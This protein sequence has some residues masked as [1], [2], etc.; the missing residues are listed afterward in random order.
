MI[1]LKTENNKT[2]HKLRT[3]L[4]QSLKAPIDAMW[5]L[6][7]IASSKH[8][9]IEEDGE[10]IG[11][12][13]INEEGALLQIYLNEDKALNM[14]GVIQKLLASNLM[15][16]ANLSSN[17]PIGFNSC[18]ALSKSIEVNTFCFENNNK[19][20]ITDS[21]LQVDLVSKVDIPAIKSF[22]MEQIGMDDNFG[23]TENLVGRKE[24]YM[25]KEQDEIIAISECRISDSQPGIVDLG[26]IV[27]KAFQGKGI[28]SQVF[29]L[30]VNRVLKEGNKPICSTTSDNIASRKAIEKAGFYCSN[31]IFNIQF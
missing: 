5:E 29:Q 12:C 16:S 26:I 19:S 9:L 21:K 8:Y 13:C 10:T 15:N 1:F 27:N 24:L 7:Y 22:L 6:L 4:Y 25:L 28:A 2:V 30:Q 23:Y 18:L 11:F 20:I 17:E 14:L 31:I 3:K